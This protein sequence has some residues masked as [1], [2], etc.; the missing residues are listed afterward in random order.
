[1]S[2]FDS[3]DSDSRSRGRQRGGKGGRRGR[4]PS[5]RGNERLDDSQEALAVRALQNEI[6]AAIKEVVRLLLPCG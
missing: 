2:N 5:G 4:S 6:A 1:M 3:D